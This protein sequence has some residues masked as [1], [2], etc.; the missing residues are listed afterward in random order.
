MMPGDMS[1]FC[2][3]FVDF[4]F[5]QRV[6]ADNVILVVWK[7]K[8]YMCSSGFYYDA[9]AGW[10]YNT[11]NGQY[12]I[13]ENDAYV[14]LAATTSDGSAPPGTYSFGMYFRSQIWFRCFSMWQIF[15]ENCG[16]ILDVVWD[17]HQQTHIAPH[18]PLLC[19]SILQSEW[20]L[21]PVIETAL[22]DESNQALIQSAGNLSDEEGG[23]REEIATA[24]GTLS[25]SGESEVL[26]QA[27]DDVEEAAVHE[28]SSRIVKDVA[29]ADL[30]SQPS[31]RH[32]QN[33]AENSSEASSGLIPGTEMSLLSMGTVPVKSSDEIFE[34]TERG[35]SVVEPE[36]T[37]PASVW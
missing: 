33:L 25:P 18:K 27:D 37:R 1:I 2:G 22:G 23:V 11:K 9:K 13:Y 17:G 19:L 30:S 31:C 35:E 20:W 26:T 29:L 21:T 7:G 28:S 32:V 34:A 5:D 15:G 8:P 16:N 10:Y 3:F 4:L 12:Y 24:Q 14:P 6:N 36:E